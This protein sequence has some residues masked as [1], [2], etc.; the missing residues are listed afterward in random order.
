[1]KNF[2]HAIGN[3][4][5]TILVMLLIGY[6]WAFFEIKIML[7]SNPELFGYIFYQQKEDDMVPTFNVDDIVI[8]KKDENFQSGDRI[9]YLDQNS[10]FKIQTVVATDAISTTTKCDTCNINNAPIAN[11]TILG[12]AVGKIAYFGKFI[13]FFKQKWFLVLLATSGFGCVIAS[14]YMRTNNTVK[15]EKE[16]I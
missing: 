15:K 7:K 6:G 2:V 8:I 11:S 10:D 3:A 5:L 14:Q 12:K 13:D 9:M 16:S 1:M 4:I